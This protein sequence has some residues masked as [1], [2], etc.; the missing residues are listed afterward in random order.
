MPE[1]RSVVVLGDFLLLSS[2]FGFSSSFPPAKRSAKSAPALSTSSKSGKDPLEPSF[3][4]NGLPSTDAGGAPFS[5][6]GP[7]PEGESGRPALG[8]SGVNPFFGGDAEGDPDLGTD[9]GG[10][11]PGD[12]GNWGRE[13]NGILKPGI[14]MARLFRGPV[15]ISSSVSLL[16]FSSGENISSV[17][18]SIEVGAP[19][20]PS[21]APA[22]LGSISL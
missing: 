3:R 18:I 17:E 12:P 14:L 15:S 11:P 13:R 7:P 9:A 20:D 16:V 5:D 1:L 19:C 6:L 8:D 22:V 10:L 2:S 21:R 4:M